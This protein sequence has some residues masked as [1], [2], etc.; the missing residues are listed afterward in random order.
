M[1]QTL[2]QPS[3][4]DAIAREWW[5]MP[6]AEACR[7]VAPPQPQT[8]PVQNHPATLPPVP[9]EQAEPPMALTT[10]QVIGLLLMREYAG[11]PKPPDVLSEVLRIQHER[12]MR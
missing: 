10:K 5:G 9:V 11:V 7:P 6:P 12:G 2:T 8:P 1:A 3:L 4:W